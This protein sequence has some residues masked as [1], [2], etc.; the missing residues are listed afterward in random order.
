MG[1]KPLI[2]FQ[3]YFKL[4]RARKIYSY[5]IWKV[6]PPEVSV[7]EVRSHDLRV[8]E[9]SAAGADVGERAA[10]HGA[11]LKEH[12]TER[13]MLKAARYKGRPRKNHVLQRLVEGFVCVDL[14][15]DELCS[16]RVLQVPQCADVLGEP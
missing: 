3:L 14:V 10:V 13:E 2:Y 1:S 7:N 15:R 11:V 12:M 8:S 4:W 16:G 5:P 9:E 6:S